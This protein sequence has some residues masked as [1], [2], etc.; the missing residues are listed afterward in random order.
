VFEGKL[1]GYVAIDLEKAVG[2]DGFRIYANAFQIHG[3][4]G[5]SRDLVGN[6]N[7]ISNIEALP[8]TRPS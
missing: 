3:T 1:E 5:I 7:T 2:L 8:T 6:F 4:G